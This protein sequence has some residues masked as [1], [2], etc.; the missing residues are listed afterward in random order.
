MT[1]ALLEGSAAINGGVNIGASTDQRGYSLIDA[2]D[3][4]AFEFGATAPTGG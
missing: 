1:H 3:I 2:D 4:G